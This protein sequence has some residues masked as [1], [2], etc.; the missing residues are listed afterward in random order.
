MQPAPALGEQGPWR[1]VGRLD[2][3]AAADWDALR[4][5]DNPFV[6]HAFL[7]GLERHGCLRPAWG[8][9]PH[10]VVLCDG[11]RPLAAAPCYRKANSHGEFVFDHG[12]A[13][14]YR[15]HRLDYYPKLLCA[16][17]YSPVTGPRLLAGNGADADH[18]RASLGRALVAEAERLGVSSVH[19]N[20]GLAS[21]L[22]ALHTDARWLARHDWQFHWH[23]RGWRDFDDFLDALTARKRKNIRQERGR[24]TGVDIEVLDGHQASERDLDDMFAFYAATFLQKGNS[25]ALTRAFFGHLAQAMPD[26]LVLVLARRAGR[27]VAGAMLL[28][29]ADTLYGRYWGASD[30]HASEPARGLHF[31]LCYYQGIEYCLRHRLARFEPGAQGEHKLARGFLPVATHSRHLLFDPRFRAAV[32]DSLVE[33]DQW[34]AQYRRELDRHAPYRSPGAGADGPPCT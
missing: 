2:E 31:E 34:L 15:R 9:Q 13:E 23:D 12:W 26:A 20:F 3:I 16:V 27:A 21:D 28:R 25:P 4:P 32:A 33:E 11:G 19:L 7:A 14:A 10:H 22:A 29:S 18:R 6:A 8:W 5:D 30:E 24:V 1:V 17:P